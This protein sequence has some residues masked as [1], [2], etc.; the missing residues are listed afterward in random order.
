MRRWQVLES[1][2][3]EIGDCLDPRPA[4][5]QVHSQRS[6]WRRRSHHTP[7]VVLDHS[8]RHPTKINATNFHMSPQVTGRG[9]W[10]RRSLCPFPHACLDPSSWIR[11]LQ[12]RVKPSPSSLERRHTSA[13][14]QNPDLCLPCLSVWPLARAMTSMTGSFKTPEQ[15]GTCKAPIGVATPKCYRAGGRARMAQVTSW[16]CLSNS[17]P[18]PTRMDGTAPVL[19]SRLLRHLRL[20][21]SLTLPTIAQDHESP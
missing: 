20:V 8:I 14:A 10:H 16:L 4:I 7:K 2:R 18:N 3:G 13:A 17:L 5:A 21:R 6:A 12:L 11:R 1:G 15:G 9:P 19:E